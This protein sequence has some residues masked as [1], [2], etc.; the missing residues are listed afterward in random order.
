VGKS[1]R[2]LLR[3]FKHN[4]ATLHTGRHQRGLLHRAGFVRIEATA[5]YDEA[6]G[7]SELVRKLATARVALWTKSDR[8]AQIVKLGWTDRTELK[9]ISAAWKAWGESPDAFFARAWGQ[10][11]GWK[12]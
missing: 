9:K 8:A 2:L 11:V 5:A 10:A 7:T 6:S 3:L 1:Q 12:E 4:G